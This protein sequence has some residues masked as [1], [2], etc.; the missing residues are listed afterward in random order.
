M[1]PT[2]RS[3]RINCRRRS[4]PAS[5]VIR[6]ESQIVRAVVARPCI[7]HEVWIRASSETA[8]VAGEG[9]RDAVF[10]FLEIEPQNRA[11]HANVLRNARELMPLHAELFRPE[12]HHLHEAHRAG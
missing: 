3:M 1:P 9:A 7:H 2:S 4:L 10:F 6:R 5:P 12:R 11:T 8:V